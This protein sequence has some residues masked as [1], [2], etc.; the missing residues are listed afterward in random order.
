MPCA[1]EARCRCLKLAT[2]LPEMTFQTVT[3]SQSATARF[4]PSREK[5]QTFALPISKTLAV[6]PRVRSQT[7][8]FPLTESSL[9]LSEK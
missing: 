1:P 6:V 2:A 4:A 7:R 9:F 5:W 8:I 3:V